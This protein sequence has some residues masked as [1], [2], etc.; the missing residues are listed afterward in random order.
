MEIITIGLW[1]SSGM[2]VFVVLGM[3]VAFAAGL[4]GFDG[5]VWLRWNGF[6]YDPDEEWAIQ[7][8]EGDYVPENCHYADITCEDEEEEQ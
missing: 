7:T 8:Y 6:D 2:L 4:A 1:V 3:R 5:L